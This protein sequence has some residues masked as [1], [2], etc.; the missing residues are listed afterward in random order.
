[1]K[2]YV[3]RHGITE[4]NKKRILNAQID[5]PLSPE[6]I[7]Q[8]K[9]AVLLIPKSIIQIYVSPMLRAQQTAQIIN[10]QL[11]RPL[12]IQNALT[13]I[14]MGSLAGHSWDQMEAGTEL[15]KKHRSMQFDYRQH[16][17][18]SVGQVKKRVLNFLSQ[19]NGK[20][21]DYEGLIVAH[22]GIIRL[23]YLLENDAPLV[24]EIEHISLNIF[25]LDKI[26]Q[27]N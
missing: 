16:G 3:V 4:L 18:E 15:K 22:G 9:V 23:L 21:K 17:G 5:E 1:M 12:L 13:E 19:I 7:E 25:D 27:K 11:H 8:A 26:L 24:D 10:S 6:G 14:H 2:I 20:H